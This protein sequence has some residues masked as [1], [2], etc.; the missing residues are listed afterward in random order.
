MSRSSTS[1]R[2]AGQCRLTCA[3]RIRAAGHDAARRSGPPRRRLHRD[4]PAHDRRDLPRICAGGSGTGHGG[5]F[6]TINALS[7][8]GMQRA[9]GQR[10]VMFCFFGGGH[11]G[12]PE[13]DG[14]NHGNAPISTATIPPLEILEAAYPVR[15]TQWA[16]RPDSGG[17][18]TYRGGLGAI[19]EIELLRRRG[20]SVHFRRAGTLGAA[21]H[22]GRRGGRAQR[23]RYQSRTVQGIRRRWRRRC[24]ASALSAASGCGS[25]RP[26]AAVTGSASRIRARARDAGRYV[27][28]ASARGNMVSWSIRRRDRCGSTQRCE[29]EPAMTPSNVVGV[30]VGGTFTDLFV[31]DEKAK[32]R[33]RAQGAVHA[34]RGSARLHERHAPRT[35]ARP[36]RSRRSCTA[37]RSA[38]MPCSNAR[39]RDGIITTR[40]FRDVLE[41]RRRDRPRTWGL[42]GDFAPVVPRDLRLEVNERVLADGTLHTRVDRRGGAGGRARAARTRLRGGLLCSSSTPMP[43]RPTNSKPSRAARAVWPNEFVT[44]SHRGAARNPRIR[45]MLDARL[46][47]TLQPVVGSYLARLD[48]RSARCRSMAN[49][50]RASNGGV[51]SR[52]D[53]AS[54]AGAHRAVGP[55]SRR[56]R[57]R[58]HRARGGL[59]EMRSPA[60]WAALHSTFRWL[61]AARR[62]SRRRRRSTSAW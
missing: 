5:P 48:R 44:A 28:P 56:D 34:G 60:T 47:A 36:A 2:R 29:A 61:P 16:L 27:T 46:N 1:F 37:P 10:W 14:L 35:A 39:W 4:D 26:A 57:V 51:M 58:R 50:G 32:A 53:R 54:T 62:R 19:Y 33:A 24:S 20:R 59:S 41:M 8:S 18:G 31:L 6:G 11:G 15:F 12:H 3:D 38:P 17:D 52:P 42:R 9:Q 30:D 49:S 7:I 40:G 13:G 23:F 55:R 22:R 21:R 45:T 43:T 25:K